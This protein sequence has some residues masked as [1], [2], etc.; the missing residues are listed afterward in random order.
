MR[1]SISKIVLGLAICAGLIAGPAIGNAAE[2]KKTHRLAV[3]ISS[4][5]PAIMNLALNNVVNVAQ[6]F[7]KSSEEF[8]I[9]VVAYG[10]GLH[11]LRD[12]TSP[13]KARVKSIGESMPGVTFTA[14]GNTQENMKKAEG[15]DI[16]LVPQA[17]VV[18]AGVVRLMELQEKGWSYVRP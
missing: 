9:E 8:E 11:M 17:K 14:C 13:V 10:P 6:E 1:F 3:Q 16:V 12:D 2:E 7:S 15:K 18:K 4:N 5:D